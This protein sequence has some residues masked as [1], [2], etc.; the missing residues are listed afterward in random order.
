[1][2]SNELPN[3]FG[4]PP[5]HF[6]CRTMVVP[7]YTKTSEIGERYTGIKRDDE[8]IRHVDKTGV[9]RV[10]DIKAANGDHHLRMRL[11]FGQLSKTDIIKAL[12]SI[13]KVAP[14]KK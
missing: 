1:G 8:I 5:Y 9:E 11:N 12:N 14:N 4:L 6:H 10:L 2:R 7:V 13:N 3:N